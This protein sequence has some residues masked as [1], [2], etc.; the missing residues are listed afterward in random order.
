MFAKGSQGKIK[1][2]SDSLTFSQRGQG[3]TRVCA[4]L[5]DGAPATCHGTGGVPVTQLLLSWAETVSTERESPFRSMLTMLAHPPL[6]GPQNQ[7]R[8]QVHRGQ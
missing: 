1:A 2:P 6:S 3:T 8:R 7:G 5:P 4:S